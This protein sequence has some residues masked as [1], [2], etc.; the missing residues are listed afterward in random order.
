MGNVHQLGTLPRSSA[1]NQTVKTLTFVG[2][3]LCSVVV[4]AVTEWATAP[5]PLA[6]FG[7]VGQ[8][9]F[10][11]FKDPSEA[12]ALRVVDFDEE[13]ASAREFSVELRDGVWRIPSHYDYPADAAERLAKTAASVIGITRGALVSRHASDHERYGVVDPLADETVSLKGRGQRLTLFKKG[14]V[15]L[16]D[17]IIGKKVEGE[18]NVY[19]VRRADEKETYRAKLEI[20]LSTKFK[21]WVERDLLKASSSDFVALEGER[22]IVDESR[23]PIIRV[24]GMEK[25]RL[26][27][28]DSLSD[29]ELEGLDPEKEELDRQAVDDMVFALSDLELVGVRPKPRFRGKPLLTADLKFNLPEEFRKQPE[30]RQ[31]A[32]QTLMADLQDKG[33]F[34]ASAEDGSTRLFSREGRLYAGTKDGVAYW[35]HFGNV[36]TGTEKEIELGGTVSKESEA[37]KKADGKDDA[38]QGGD[39]QDEGKQGD[40]KAGKEDDQQADEKA[41]KKDDGED[42]QESELQKS[43]FVFIRATVDESLLGPKPTEPVKPKKPEGLEEKTSELQ[44]GGDEKATGNTDTKKTPSKNAAEGGRGTPAD[45]GGAAAKPSG[46]GAAS[47]AP[48]G[49]SKTKR[50]GAAD[51]SNG[52]TGGAEGSNQGAEARATSLKTAI[53]SSTTGTNDA[54]GSAKKTAGSSSSVARGPTGKPA[55]GK[56]EADRKAKGAVQPS[57]AGSDAPKTGTEVSKAANA[58]AEAESTKATRSTAAG[59]DSAKDSKSKAGDGDGAKPGEKESAAGGAKP[60]ETKAD[61]QTGAKPAPTGK[62]DSAKDSN[63]KAGAAPEGKEQ[64]AQAKDAEASGKSEKAQP[65]DPKKAYEEAMKEYERKLEQYKRE[66]KEYEEKLQKAKEK[67]AEL[68]ARFADWYYLISADAFDKLR[69]TRDKLVKPKQKE[70]EEDAKD[71]DKAG[72]DAVETPKN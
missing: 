47:N 30:L 4:L 23:F 10:P 65:K 21:D 37:S 16:A 24:V 61:K 50:E 56:A 63:G 38:G 57:K 41:D 25:Y 44:Q 31:L 68:N 8:P 20:D 6:E 28:K 49:E 51:T 64:P 58:G 45:K 70:K 66:L 33:F 36:F 5:K 7:K 60:E 32:E 53:A 15:V 2:V 19:Y 34:L 27:R 29:W 42:K 48:G 46:G 39:S 55:S 52:K 3:A 13:T 12:V 43:R 26:T 67:V 1:M 40:D 11:E 71:G 22:P 62:K 9:F 59:S 72:Q 18:D 35:L 54:D 14:E 69:L 17:L